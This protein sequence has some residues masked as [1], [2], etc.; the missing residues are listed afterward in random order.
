M[1]LDRTGQIWQ[2]KFSNGKSFI[3][4][5]LNTQSR[6]YAVERHEVLVLDGYNWDPYR[7]TT[8]LSE[9][10]FVQDENQDWIKLY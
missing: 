7:L 1:I 9:M 5:I 4:L 8:N 10:Y 3:F 2:G 6:P